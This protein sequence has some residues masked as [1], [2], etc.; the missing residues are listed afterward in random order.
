M[1]NTPKIIG[2]LSKKEYLAAVTLSKPENNPVAIVQPERENP[3][4]AASP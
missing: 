1:P 4:K 3:G 2:I